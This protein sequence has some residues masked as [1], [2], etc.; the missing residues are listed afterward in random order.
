[1]TDRPYLTSLLCLSICL[2]ACLCAPPAQADELPSP[3][4]PEA[5]AL[6]VWVP[7]SGDMMLGTPNYTLSFSDGSTLDLG[8]PRL[9]RWADKASGRVSKLSALDLKSWL[10]VVSYYRTERA[11]KTLLSAAEKLIKRDMVPGDNRYAVFKA[12]AVTADQRSIRKLEKMLDA[13][14][15]NVAVIGAGIREL[16]HRPIMAAT[17]V[18]LDQESGRDYLVSAYRE[19][20]IDKQNKKAVVTAP[21]D[22]LAQFNDTALIERVEA[23]K[24]DPNL[25][26]RVT[27]RNIESLLQKMRDN[28]LPLEDLRKLIDDDDSNRSRRLHAVQVLGER[29]LAE[30]IKRLED[31]SVLVA[32]GP[33]ADALLK[34]Y[35]DWAIVVIRSR[36]WEELK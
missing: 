27:Q 30:D 26:E 3:R 13:P 10:S 17:L 15:K 16:G 4:A 14:I 35:T 18:R 8:D 34:K 28:G 11:N 31:L 25:Q 24:E 12:L 6:A 29:G 2:L 32:K 36:L 33:N 9:A 5:P 21:F 1:M 19:L 22:L 20:L 7:Y 23:L